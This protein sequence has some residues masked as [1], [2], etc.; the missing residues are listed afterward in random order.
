MRLHFSAAARRHI[1]DIYDFLA[2]RNLA[3]A[4]R[5]VGEI[6]ASTRLLIEY[7]HMGRAG[8]APGTRE[9]IIRG[10][11]YLVVYEVIMQSQE[12]WVLGIFHGA[13]DWQGRS[14]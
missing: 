1:D 9:W 4:R 14:P 8:N 7:P 11:P 3:A 13:Q 10:S 5:I 6:R 12:I 2:E